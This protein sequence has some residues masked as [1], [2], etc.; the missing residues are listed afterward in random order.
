MQY[1]QN[2]RIDRARKLLESCDVPL[3]VLAARCGFGS[4]RHMRKV[5]SER[6]GLSPNQYRQQFGGE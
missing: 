3:K 2:A 1:V 5:F 6:I 4:A